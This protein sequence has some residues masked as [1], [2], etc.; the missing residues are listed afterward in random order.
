[1][2][3]GFTLPTADEIQ[4]AALGT[5]STERVRCM[6]ILVAKSNGAVDAAVLAKHRSEL[7]AMQTE[8]VML[9]SDMSGFTRLTKQYGILHFLTLVMHCRK[10]FRNH[11]EVHNGALVKYDGDNI[12]IKFATCEGAVKCVRGI[13]N[14]INE[15]N[16]GKEKDFQVRVKLGMSA[17]Q[18]L[19]I[20]HDIVGKA[21]EECCL[22]GED[23]AEVGEV[24]VT[25]SVKEELIKTVSPEVAAIFQFERRA[26]EP[27][28]NGDRLVH[29]NLSFDDTGRSA[30]TLSVLGSRTGRVAD[31][32]VVEAAAE[33]V[34]RATHRE[35]ELVSTVAAQQRATD[36]ARAR[37]RSLE[38]ALVVAN[39]KAKRSCVCVV[40][41]GLVPVDV[42][43]WAGLLCLESRAWQSTNSWG[44]PSL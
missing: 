44:F 32:A 38:A 15:F 17:G 25:E 1:M 16:E 28:S 19:I 11:L 31:E 2:L 23:T 18:M 14:E 13:Y 20:G 9:Q 12:I 40:V 29:Y 24:L 7:M 41:L 30:T 4:R 43:R 8:C 37:I 39:E 22:L 42:V 5:N 35:N 26:T 34:E 33:A 3:P 6:D 36:A 27:D 10:I 21:W